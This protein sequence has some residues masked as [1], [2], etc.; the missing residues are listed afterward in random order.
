MEVPIYQD[1]EPKA[2][3]IVEV[4]ASNVK[5]CAAGTAQEVAPEAAPEPQAEVTP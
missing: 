3:F 4:D 5:P 2:Q 1:P